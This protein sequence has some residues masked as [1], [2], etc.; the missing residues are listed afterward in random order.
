[1]GHHDDE[2]AAAYVRTKCGEAAGDAYRCFVPPAY[3][4]DTFRFCALY[5]DGGIY[6]DEDIVPLFP[7][8]ELYSPCSVASVGHDMPQQQLGVPQRSGKFLAGKQMKILASAPGAPIFKCA[9]DTLIDHV[10]KRYHPENPLD[11]S[12]PLMLHKSYAKHSEGVAIT[13]IDTR[14]AI[15]PFTGLR[16]GDRVLAYEATNVKRHFLRNDDDDDYDKLYKS[17]NVFTSA[18]TLKSIGR[19]SATKKIR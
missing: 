13:Y 2:S 6:L 3:R 5:V 8:Q 15:W 14:R 17:G 11:L 7:L 9:L 16:A 12:G 18:C 1:M 10:R 4:A 19:L